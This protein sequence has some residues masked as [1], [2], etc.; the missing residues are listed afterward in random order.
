MY[1]L[2]LSLAGKNETPVIRLPS[3]DISVNFA[4]IQP[5]PVTTPLQPFLF[6]TGSKKA[7]VRLRKGSSPWSPRVSLG[8]QNCTC[9]CIP[10]AAPFTLTDSL[11]SVSVKRL[12]EPFTATQLITISPQYVFVNKTSMDLWIQQQDQSFSLPASSC[13]CHTEFLPG[14]HRLLSIKRATSNS[15]STEFDCDGSERMDVVLPGE[16]EDLLSVTTSQIGDLQAVTIDMLKPEDISYCVSN[17]SALDRITVLQSACDLSTALTVSP[18]DPHMWILP[19]PVGVKQAVIFLHQITEAETEVTFQPFVLV[20][21]SKPGIVA[22]VSRKN[23]DR[24]VEI[25]VE[26]EDTTK[27][28]ARLVNE[29]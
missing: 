21:L 15:Y 19:N 28:G 12:Q 23:P 18:M 29:G 20:H 27:V 3:A 2:Y 6:N 24:V 13:I 17:N 10:A 9:V 4:S 1:F 14:S 26:A 25:V 7:V 8:K 5:D 22:T 16:P 11:Y